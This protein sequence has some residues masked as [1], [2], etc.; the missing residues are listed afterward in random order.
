MSNYR[1][2]WRWRRG[3][4]KQMGVGKPRDVTIGRAKTRVYHPLPPSLPAVTH[5]C[6][7]LPDI[8]VL[9][10]CAEG[11]RTAGAGTE[12][13]HSA[14]DLVG[15]DTLTKVK[16]ICSTGVVETQRSRDVSSE[17]LLLATE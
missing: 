7:H 3:V 8:G 11:L 4:V 15:I 6:L 14:A 9:S 1:Q 16:R 12:Q 17:N 13:I 5:T 2:T 10:I